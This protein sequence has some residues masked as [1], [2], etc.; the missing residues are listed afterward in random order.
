MS[1]IPLDRRRF[2]WNTGGGLGGIALRTCS[3]H[4]DCSR[5]TRCSPNRRPAS[6]WNTSPCSGEPRDRIIHVR[7]ASQCD[8]Y[9]YKPLLIKKHGEVRPGGQDRAVP[10]RAGRRDEEPLGL[11]AVRRVRQVDERPGAAP[12]RVR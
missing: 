7:R 5:R 12:G 9:D 1:P 8:L 11:E 2:L 4:T 3:D 6:L 10:E